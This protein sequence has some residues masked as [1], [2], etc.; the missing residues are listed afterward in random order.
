MNI[1]VD[2]CIWS[3]MFR[4][5][6]RSGLSRVA[7]ELIELIRERR[8]VMLGSVRQELL[9]GIKNASNFEALCQQLRAFDDL[10]VERKDYE[11][12]AECFNRCRQAGIQGSNTDFLICALSVRHELPVFST[13]KDFERY[14][15]HLKFKLHSVRQS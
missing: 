6:E 9:S 3:E 15:H 13:D 7:L 14:H 11:S 10:P 12:A 5:Q 8:A 2:T 4:R 1:L